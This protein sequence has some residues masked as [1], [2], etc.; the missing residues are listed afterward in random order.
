M[1]KEDFNIIS[2]FATSLMDDTVTS[3]GISQEEYDK[4]VNECIFGDDI[5]RKED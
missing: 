4:V 2:K 3:L 1:D 5:V